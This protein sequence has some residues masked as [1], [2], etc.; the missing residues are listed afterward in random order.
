M[1]TVANITT[2]LRHEIIII[3]IRVT[4][5][6]NIKLAKSSATVVGPFMTLSALEPLYGYYGH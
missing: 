4:I 1:I 3:V 5:P 2:V 6:T